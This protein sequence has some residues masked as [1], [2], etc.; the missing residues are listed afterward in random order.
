M[1][2]FVN[3]SKIIPFKGIFDDLKD[4]KYFATVSVSRDLGTIIWDNGADI[5]PECLY[6]NLSSEI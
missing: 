5:S 4:E 1:E 3:I 2:G 6:E